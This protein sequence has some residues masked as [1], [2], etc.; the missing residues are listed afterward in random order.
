[1]KRMT[2]I[3]ATSFLVLLFMTFAQT[4]TPLPSITKANA[5][6]GSYFDYVVT[7]LM[8]N[9]GIN[10]VC[11]GSVSLT[12]PACGTSVAPYMG[13]LANLNSLALHYT[14]TSHP[15]EGNYISLIGGSNFGHTGD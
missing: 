3:L 7:I 13:A 2:L 12:Q 1:M 5:A 11:G 9:N 15:S 8:E 14:G 10:D 4:S 6:P